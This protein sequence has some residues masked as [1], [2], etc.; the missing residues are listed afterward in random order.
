MHRRPTTMLWWAAALPSASVSAAAK[1]RAATPTVDG[2]PS[3]GGSGCGREDT[4]RLVEVSCVAQAPG[5]VLAPSL[6]Q[7][8]R[9]GW[10]RAPWIVDGGDGGA[11]RAAGSAGSVTAP[12][13]TSTRRTGTAIGPAAKTSPSGWTW[14]SVSG[15]CQGATSERVASTGVAR[16]ATVTW[17]SAKAMRPAR[18]ARGRCSA[19]RSRPACMRAST[20]DEPSRDRTRDTAS[21]LGP[22]RNVGEP[23]RDH[24]GVHVDR[25]AR[26][27]PS[28]RSCV[29]PSVSCASPPAA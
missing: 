29:L 12:R 3:L 28:R 16:V 8:L 18:S 24:L 19:T 17:A 11:V 21:R 15:G 25:A 13:S 10:A 23:R 9:V 1:A 5:L 4:P 20:A 6:V 22:R 2:R 7:M 26:Q 14:G 27:R